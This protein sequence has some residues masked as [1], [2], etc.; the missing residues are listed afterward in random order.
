M[1]EDQAI[2]LEDKEKAFDRIEWDWLFATLKFFGFGDKFISFLK[3]MY[4]DAKSSVITNGYQSEYFDIT[5]G[6]RQGDMLSALLYIIQM[7]P[8]AEKIRQNKS[9]KGIKV[10][11]N[12]MQN[13]LTCVLV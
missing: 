7:E 11:L 10:K 8:L 13:L 9:I 6:I 5:R 4:K 3:S 2:F 1:D 12:N